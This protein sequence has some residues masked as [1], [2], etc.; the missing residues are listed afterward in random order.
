MK[1]WDLKAEDLYHPGLQIYHINKDT[2]HDESH[3]QAKHQVM[4]LIQGSFQTQSH[5]HWLHW[6]PIRVWKFWKFSIKRMSQQAW[7]SF[8]R[9][10][11]QAS[12]NHCFNNLMKR[13]KFN[14]ETIL[15]LVWFD[16]STVNKT[17]N[18]N[19]SIYDFQQR[20]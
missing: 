9:H 2:T 17:F 10:L 15:A 5:S 1:Q 12:K 7:S 13:N 16:F 8:Q 4:L 11:H 6:A 14:E 20:S 19:K 18:Q 3:R